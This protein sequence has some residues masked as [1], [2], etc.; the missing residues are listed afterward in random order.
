MYLF[1][2]HLNF[3]TLSNRI[4]MFIWNWIPCKVFMTATVHLTS[5][6]FHWSVIKFLSH[7]SMGSTIFSVW[8]S[9]KQYMSVLQGSSGLVLIFMVCWELFIFIFKTWHKINFNIKSMG[10]KTFQHVHSCYHYYSWLPFI[11]EICF[12][13]TIGSRSNIFDIWN[14]CKVFTKCTHQSGSFHLTLALFSRFFD[15]C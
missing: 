5:T 8:N 4:T 9:C 3:L 6:S 1:F 7:E 15:Q 11:L 10:N 2:C 13:N 12:S 14:D